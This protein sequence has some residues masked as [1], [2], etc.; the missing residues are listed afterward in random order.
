MGGG[1]N[2][3]IMSETRLC[4]ECRRPVEGGPCAHCLLG[5]SG[6][7]S[8]LGARP[9]W[10]DL[11][12]AGDVFEVIDGFAVVR[13]LGEGGMGEVFLARQLSTG[14]EVA[15]KLLRASVPL[16][17][18]RKEIAALAVLRHGGLVPILHAGEHGG[19]PYYA[20]EYVDG[21]D[22]AVRMRAD[23]PGAREAVGWMVQVARAIGHAHGQGIL[24]RDLKPQNI[25]I[26]LDGAARVTDFGLARILGEEGTEGQTVPGMALGTPAYMA[27]EQVRGTRGDEGPWTDVYGMGATLYCLLTGVA[28]FRAESVESLFR[29]VLQEE[30]ASPR[31]LRPGLDLDLETVVLG[32]MEKEAGARYASA[33]EWADE[34]ERWQRGEPIRRRPLGWMGRL[35]KWSR[36]RPVVAALSGALVCVAAM[37]AAGVGWQWRQTVAANRRMES[38]LGELRLAE[39]NRLVSGGKLPEAMRVLARQ[40]REVPGD[41]A[42]AARL[43]SLLSTRRF[44]LPVSRI[45][46]M[47]G[48]ILVVRWAPDGK[49]VLVVSF[50]ATN[51]PVELRAWDPAKQVWAS[52]VRTLGA[53]PVD[54]QY[55]ADGRWVLTQ[56]GDGLRLWRA[57]GLEQVGDPVAGVQPQAEFAWH[58]LRAEF[59]SWAA[60]GR[61]FCMEAETRRVVWERDLG[62]PVRCVTISR[63]GRRVAVGLEGSGVVM[64]EGGTG[65]PVGE[66]LPSPGPV[67]G[68]T[69][70]G[71]GSRL[72]MTVTSPTEQDQPRLE[73]LWWDVLEGRAVGPLPTSGF[74]SFSADGSLLQG[75]TAPT[76]VLVASNGMFGV[77][78]TND[79]VPWTTGWLEESTEMA[80]LAR[81]R[82]LRIRDISTGVAVTEP[83]MHPGTVEDV[84]P[85]PD[86][87]L[88]VTTD[89]SSEAILWASRRPVAA[90]RE[91][92]GARMVEVLPDGS[93]FVTGG[94]EGAVRWHRSDGQPEAGRAAQMAGVVQVLRS[95]RT[96][97]FV[98][99]GT[100]TGDVRLWD[101][102]A[103]GEG[104]RLDWGSGSVSSAAF[105]PDERMLAVLGGNSDLRFYRTSDGAALTP[106]IPAEAVNPSPRG[107]GSWVVAFHPDGRSVVVGSYGLDAS[108]WEAGTTNRIGGLAHPVGAVSV[109][110]FAPDGSWLA[111]GSFDGT[112]RIW[113]WASKAERIAPM[114]HGSAVVSM[115]VSPDGAMVASGG[116]LGVVRLWRV[117]DGIEHRELIGHS[118]EGPGLVRDLRFSPDGRFLLSASGDRTVRF[119]D[120][121]T[122]LMVSDPVSMG[123]EAVAAQW[124][125]DGRHWVA[126]GGQGT[127]VR[128]RALL[129]VGD[130]PSWLPRVADA[131]A[132]NV[133]GVNAY[134]EWEKARG[135]AAGEPDGFYRD[136]ARWFFGERVG[137]D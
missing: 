98:V 110:G 24:H 41:A 66:R 75:V 3:R 90:P 11:G 137:R 19:R 136:W 92:P 95:G 111:T 25:L 89:V 121:A 43:V 126:A 119:W 58:P 103:A 84:A 22:L 49:T 102:D 18:F 28:P 51:G 82:E 79:T 122:G 83:L 109:L 74:A 69:L 6:G 99:G 85:S 44:L 115:A 40:L 133:S 71:D 63:D 33:G 7:A 31:L 129:P 14:R 96:G 59:I 101:R 64:L 57:A 106:A 116:N 132:G 134:G 78:L 124:T 15:L 23:P 37:G 104:R 80:T 112:V 53:N 42:S 62:G 50:N 55:S 47:P 45:G 123:G 12:E 2:Q 61:V 118:T 117:K 52:E 20:M 21:P 91:L 97:R 5:P 68:V 36:R 135:M 128:M 60:E 107:Q 34:L 100:S 120:V 77:T 65:L 114:R 39:A 56:F 72:A 26:G 93:G 113:D 88:L 125:P 17:R 127:G 108:L 32:A 4:P 46:P 131:M 8:D 70:N 29:M 1:E 73:L 38:S 10:E 76:R 13:R 9:L 130:A 105:S 27:P 35:V 81:S 94:N 16:A 30:P 86:G 54:L 67:V 87:N 48:S